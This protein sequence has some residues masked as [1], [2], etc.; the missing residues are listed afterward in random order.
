MTSYVKHTFSAG[1]IFGFIFITALFAQEKINP[2]KYYLDNGLKVILVEMH[3]SPIIIQQLF[4]R[5]GSRNEHVGKTGISHVVEHMM[6]KGTKKYPSGKI[7]TLIKRNSGVFNAYT[8]ND[9]TVYFEQLPR[10]K[11]DIALEIESDRMMKLRFRS[12]GIRAGKSRLLKKSE[13]Y[14]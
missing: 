2:Q 6:F 5:V 10:N 7:S 1:M 12:K 8:S 9:M 14:E 11:I 3:K 13:G 4:Y